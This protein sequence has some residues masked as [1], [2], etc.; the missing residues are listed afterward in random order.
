MKFD[1]YR[2]YTQ[3][4]LKY[5]VEKQGGITDKEFC[6]NY[7]ISHVTLIK[8]KKWWAQEGKLRYTDKEKIK[9]YINDLKKYIENFEAL[10]EKALELKKE[11][12]ETK[13]LLDGIKEILE[14]HGGK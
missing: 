2:R 13:E 8:A 11:K 9:I 6:E 4:M 12:F 14:Q 1:T 5:E 3:I 7:G 10:M